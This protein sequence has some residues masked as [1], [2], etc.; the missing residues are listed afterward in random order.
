MNIHVNKYIV[1]NDFF[2]I[3]DSKG[4]LGFLNYQTIQAIII[5]ILLYMAKN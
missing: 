4:I 3:M 1:D 5:A 2:I